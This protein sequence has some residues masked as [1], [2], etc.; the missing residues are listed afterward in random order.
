MVWGWVG[1]VSVMMACSQCDSNGKSTLASVLLGALL[2]C[3]FG[4]S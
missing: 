2:V 4:A 1:V 3:L